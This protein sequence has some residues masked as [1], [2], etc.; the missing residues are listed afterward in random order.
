MFVQWGLEAVL[1]LKRNKA[2]NHIRQKITDKDEAKLIQLVLSNPPEGHAR[3][4]LWLL[5]KET[6]VIL[7]HPIEKDMI[8]RLF[9]KS[10]STS[11][12]Q[13]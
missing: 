10:T 8:G 12:R 7:V 11:K 6:E 1:T 5:E 13:Y 3:W 9:K 2:S 4:S